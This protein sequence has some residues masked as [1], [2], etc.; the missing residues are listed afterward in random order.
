MVCMFY[1]NL[2]HIYQGFPV[3]YGWISLNTFHKRLTFNQSHLRSA[4][5]Y[6]I[7]ADI[8][9]FVATEMFPVSMET[10]LPRDV[11]VKSEPSCV[12]FVGKNKMSNTF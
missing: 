11:S 1:P 3:K 2:H 9:S 10:G 12:V 6:L 8:V 4:S 5:V 7:V